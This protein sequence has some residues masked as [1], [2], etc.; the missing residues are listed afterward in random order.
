MDKGEIVIA[1]EAYEA[2]YAKACEN[3]VLAM[4]RA[5]RQALEDVVRQVVGTDMQRA[6][7]NILTRSTKRNSPDIT[8][9]F[10]AF[11]WRSSPQSSCPLGA[12]GLS[13]F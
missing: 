5:N 7:V 11:L 1:V 4:A 13:T 6:A 10:P 12:P 2:G 9:G 8:T 3:F